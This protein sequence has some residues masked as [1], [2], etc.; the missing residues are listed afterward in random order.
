MTSE[1]V[2][3]KLKTQDKVQ[4]PFG[5]KGLFGYFSITNFN[6][7][8]KTFTIRIDW[9]RYDE[10]YVELK[11]EDYQKTWWFIDDKVEEKITKNDTQEVLK[12]G[13]QMLL[14]DIIDIYNGVYKNY[15][16]YYKTAL[17]YNLK[18]QEHNKLKPGENCLI[19]TY[20]VEKNILPE[21]HFNYIRFLAFKKRG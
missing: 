6:D 18:C 8:A 7:S 3:Q 10:D 20:K 12:P 13:E 5:S 2:W 11:S 21:P 16:D 15:D 14:S 1:E 9:S 17:D 19:K 4:M